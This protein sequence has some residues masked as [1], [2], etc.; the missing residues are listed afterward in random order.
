MAVFFFYRNIVGNGV[1]LG[2]TR[3]WTT[4][5]RPLEGDADTRWRWRLDQDPLSAGVKGDLI[6]TSRRV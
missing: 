6:L 5:P 3:V 2:T 4:Q 1:T